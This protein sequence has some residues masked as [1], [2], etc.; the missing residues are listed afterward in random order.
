[1]KKYFL[2]GVVIFTFVLII[3]ALAKNDDS[4]PK[5]IHEPGTGLSDDTTQTTTPTTTKLKVGNGE[6]IHEPGTGLENPELKEKNKGTGLGLSTTSDDEDDDSEEVTTINRERIRVNEERRSQVANAVQ[7][8]LQAA[9][10]LEG[11]LGIQVREIA[12]AQ[13]RI[14]EQIELGLDKLQNT[15]KIARF[16]FGPKIKDVDTLEEQLTLHEEKLEELKTSVASID[17]EEIKVQLEEQ[18][19]T[20][21]E[22]K[23]QIQTA[24]NEETSSFSLFGWVK[25][26]FK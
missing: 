4:G 6:G 10:K 23:T 1:M 26:L 16:F 7:T 12:Q 17:D 19:Q 5:G 9:D 22:V 8:M 21:E 25:K 24:I 13:N 11:G 2:I 20:M 3:P 14:Q 18:I 15:N